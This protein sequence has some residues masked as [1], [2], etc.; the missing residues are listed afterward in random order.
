MSEF[1]ETWEWINQNGTG[2]GAM[3]AI[4]AASVAAW[5]LLNT[6]LDS[7]ERTRPM[8]TAEL[9]PSPDSDS[10][11][12]LV[13]RNLGLTPARNLSLT[14]KPSILV[15]ETGGPFTTPYLIQRYAK[16]I[17]VLNPGQT[18]S[19][20]WWSGELVGNELVNAEPTPDEVT[21]FLEYGGTRRK[22]FTDE[23]SLS[24][25]TVKLTTY[26]VSSTSIKGRLKTIEGAL[27]ESAAALKT[28]AGKS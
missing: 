14:F 22:R 9:S 27:K 21:I 20:I 12:D 4:I 6:A 17:Q 1:V 7:R 5:S 18:L 26:S 3:A 2:L 24:V 25:D 23:F 10:S 16:P 15:P 19:N 13:V 8:V 11:M 28:I